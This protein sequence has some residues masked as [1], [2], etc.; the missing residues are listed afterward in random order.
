M[1]DGIY[2][3]TETRDP[4]RDEQHLQ[5][6]LGYQIVR[7]FDN[8]GPAETAA[9]GSTQVARPQPIVTPNSYGSRCSRKRPR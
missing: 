7:Y 3:G 2:T 4:E 1:F 9:G 5:P 6:Y 8:F